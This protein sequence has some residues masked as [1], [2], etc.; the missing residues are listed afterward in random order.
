MKA[1]K[2]SLTDFL[3]QYNTIFD[4]PVYQRNYEWTETQCKQ[5]F[6]DVVDV[7]NMS[8]LHHFFGTF[9]FVDEGSDALKHKFLI[10][11]GQQRLITVS[12]FLRALMAVDSGISTS[13]QK[14]YLRNLDL[15]ENNSMKIKPIA[16]DYKAYQSV[17]THDIAYN[18]SS[19][20]IENYN[21]FLKL[22][23]DSGA[24]PVELFNALSK[25]DVVLISLDGHSTDENPQVVFES[26]NST[27]LSLTQSDLTRNLLLMGADA[28]DQDRLYKQYWAKIEDS[29][30]EKM[31]NN[32]LY[33]YLVLKMGNNVIKKKLYQNYKRFYYMNNLQPESALKD[34]YL[35]SLF[36][37]RIVY[38]NTNDFNFNTS[39][40]HI[41]VVNPDIAS[42]F[43]LLL[44]SMVHSKK[45][46]QKQANKLLAYVENFLLRAEIIGIRANSLASTITTLCRVIASS[47]DFEQDLLLTLQPKFPTD[48]Q[49]QSAFLLFEC[50]GHRRASAEMLLSV[51]DKYKTTNTTDLSS[52]YIFPLK[53]NDE[54][55]ARVHDAIGIAHRYGKLIGNM[56]LGS[57]NKKMSNSVFSIKKKYY[58]KSDYTLTRNLVQFQSWGEGEIIART[59]ELAKSFVDTYKYPAFKDVKKQSLSGSTFMLNQFVNVTGLH[60]KSVTINDEEHSVSSWTDML[61]QVLNYIWTTNSHDFKLLMKDSTLK[62][63]LFTTKRAPLMLING[64]TVEG[65][66]SAADILGIITRVAHLLNMDNDIIYTVR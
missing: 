17:I 12:L 26:L 47:K 36:Y 16:R 43:A 18:E 62:S 35:Y 3:R 40:E 44:V 24:Q 7:V 54:W 19:K 60:I 6:N 2:S 53:P 29:M 5:Y 31:L 66:Y 59:K 28:S 57:V 22:I 13:I 61:K 30:P 56:A 39:L 58:A 34:L 37:S 8:D 9:V 14:Q 63:K 52:D 42:P 41:T 38:H 27:G 11:D 51:L 25:F 46:T 15:K 48:T 64:H 49:V 23:K 55:R 1:D 65:N 20:I 4:I 21:L 32:F 50:S 45:M 10:I 33:Y